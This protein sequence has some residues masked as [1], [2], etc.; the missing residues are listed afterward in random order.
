[1]PLEEAQKS[2]V[3]SSSP[4][5]DE[6][7]ERP[8]GMAHMP[9]TSQQMPGGPNNAA[10]QHTGSS[11]QSGD[12]GYR[13]QPGGSAL[14][15]SPQR[16]RSNNPFLRGRNSSPNPWEDSNQR[17]QLQSHSE[18]SSSI[19]NL[20]PDLSERNSQSKFSC[21]YSCLQFDAYFPKLQGLSL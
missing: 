21:N 6:L 19:P 14:G 5:E 3:A 12:D 1:M 18:Q 4:W 11:I 2:P 10:Y 17:D 20:R 9:E 7:V 15:T 13:K 16:F 8:V